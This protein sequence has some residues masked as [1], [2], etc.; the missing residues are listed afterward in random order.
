MPK[1][2]PIIGKVGELER[3][4]QFFFGYRFET[5]TCPGKS[6]VKSKFH[7]I[8]FFP[9]RFLGVIFGYRSGFAKGFHAADLTLIFGKRNIYICYSHD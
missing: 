2:R 3:Y 5:L 8:S 7:K 1:L 4:S 6:D 9:F